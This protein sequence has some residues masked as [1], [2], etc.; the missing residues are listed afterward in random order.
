MRPARGC[1][2]ALGM[3]PE[4]HL[5]N[6]SIA[7]ELVNEWYNTGV[8]VCV[9]VGG[10]GGLMEQSFSHNLHV[11]RVRWCS[12]CRHRLEVVPPPPQVSAPDHQT[13][14]VGL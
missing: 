9:C 12:A 10:R 1:G 4:K 13:G 8:Y 7:C 11:E 2:A 3:W 14:A 6:I 5:H